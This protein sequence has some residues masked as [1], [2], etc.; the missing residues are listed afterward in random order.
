[1]ILEPK[2]NKRNC[3]HFKGV[4]Q[5]DGTE[6]TEIVICLAFPLGIPNDIAY[7]NNKHTTIVEGQEGDYVYTPTET[8]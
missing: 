4:L 1:M 5:P 8:T 2:C 7:G 6:L 3:I